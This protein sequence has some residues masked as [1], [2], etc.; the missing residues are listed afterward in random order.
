MTK[1]ISTDAEINSVRLAEQ[2]SA[3]TGTASGY[4]NAY[5]RTNGLY[6]INDSGQDI[7]P[8]ITGSY[9]IG[10]R[11]YHNANQ[12]LSTTT[13][14]LLIFNSERYDT[15]GMHSGS[16]GQL[17]CNIAGKY[18]I[19]GNARF[20]S[21]NAGDRMLIIY[22]NGTTAIGL[23][24]VEAVEV[25]EHTT[26]NVSTIYELEVGDYVELWA[27]QASGGDLNVEVAANYSPEFMMQ[28]I[29]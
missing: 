28:K 18:I 8:F 3:P 6:L 16:S 26:I 21:D 14:T 2:G 19:S 9:D 10:A 7:G 25:A 24:R 13:S 15:N 27:Y 1:T 29:G 23:Q 20:A 4:G 17:Y 12:S 11:I 5:I 22:L